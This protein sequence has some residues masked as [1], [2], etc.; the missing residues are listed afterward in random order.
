M[1]G[2]RTTVLPIPR[3]DKGIPSDRTVMVKS[4]NPEG[5]G[6]NPD[7]TEISCPIFYL[8]STSL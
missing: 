7:R 2:I 6:S 3:Q 8:Q 5:L 4:F 1:T